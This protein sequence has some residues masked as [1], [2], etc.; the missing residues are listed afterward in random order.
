MPGE[1]LPLPRGSYRITQLY[2]GRGGH[3]GIDMGVPSGTPMFA[4]KDGVVE[5]WTRDP[6]GF[7]PNCILL[8]CDGATYLYGHGNSVQHGGQRV[9]AGTQIG[10]SGNMGLSTG[11]HLHFQ[12]TV[13]NGNT[14]TR[15]FD[16][17][18]DIRAWESGGTAQQVPGSGFV[19]AGSGAPDYSLIA[20]QGNPASNFFTG[21][22]GKVKENFS[23]VKIEGRYRTEPFLQDDYLRQVPVFGGRLFKGRLMNQY[24][25][26]ETPLQLDF[27][28]NPTS[29]KIEYNFNENALD[30][31]QMS[32]G[33][34][35][36]TNLMSGISVS[37]SILFDRTAERAARRI[38]K[39]Y[40]GSDEDSAGNVGVISDVRILDK[41]VGVFDGSGVP[42]NMP[43]KL[44]L[45]GND[46]FTFEG[47]L[48]G[49]AVE[50]QKF[51]T[52]MVPI[53]AGFAVSMRAFFVPKNGATAIA[54]DTAGHTIE[55]RGQSGVV[56][57]TS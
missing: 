48:T 27:M 42:T 35:A 33:E 43:C 9:T 29:V 18:P 52:D 41:L 37:F 46:S 50:F 16:P 55:D 44:F 7:G 47:F 10:T 23:T 14:S 49:A 36:V 13:A 57:Q 6:G 34:N 8:H 1:T 30:A 21:G 5:H 40:G 54:T 19:T 24:L 53:L 32:S 25:N 11:P 12:K 17:L 51:D 45:S 26:P 4:V 20:A 39:S 3:P 2:G 28:Y 38:D 22:V 31:S 15:T 56:G